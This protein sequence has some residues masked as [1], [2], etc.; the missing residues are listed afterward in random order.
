MLQLLDNT[1]FDNDSKTRLVKIIQVQDQEISKIVQGIK[2]RLTALLR[3]A[4][5]CLNAPK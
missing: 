3:H 2:H 4:T 1:Y 5:G